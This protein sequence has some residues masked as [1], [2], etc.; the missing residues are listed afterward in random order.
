MPRI[1][2]S[3]A[4]IRY[5]STSLARQLAQSV[6]VAD[7][8]SAIIDCGNTISSSGTVATATDCNMACSGNSTE[9]CGGP[10]RLNIFTSGK[11]APAGPGTNPGPAGWLF[12]GCYTDAVNARTLTTGVATTGGQGALTVALCT[13]ACKTAGYTLA[14]MEYSG[15]CYCGNSF[16]NGGGPAPDGLTGC[17]MPCNGNSSEYCGGSNRLNVYDYNNAVQVSSTSTSATT[18]KSASSAST[19]ASST[20][21]AGWSALGCYTDAVGGAL[22]RWWAMSLVV[23]PL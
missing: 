4:I 10:N 19:S 7:L 21:P 3:H 11:V 2:R 5:T 8:G 20:A 18:S 6:H 1:F 12:L 17:N 23:Q 14:G 16:S 13:S 22:F 15:E 9:Q